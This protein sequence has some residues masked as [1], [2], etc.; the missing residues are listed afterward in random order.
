MQQLSALK[1]SVE[2]WDKLRGRVKDTLTL[3]E[4]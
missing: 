2:S 1:E 4:S 3:V